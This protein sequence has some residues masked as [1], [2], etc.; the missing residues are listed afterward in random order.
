MLGRQLSGM[1]VRYGAMEKFQAKMHFFS[2]VT[3]LLVHFSPQGGGATKQRE[4][5]MACMLRIAPFSSGV[6]AACNKREK[7]SVSGLSQ[8]L[9]GTIYCHV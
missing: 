9:Q 5:I 7:G 1:P 2:H 3:R 4:T 6:R 8:N